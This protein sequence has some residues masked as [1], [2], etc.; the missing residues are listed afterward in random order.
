MGVTYGFACNCCGG[1]L[2]AAED[3]GFDPESHFAAYVDPPVKLACPRCQKTSHTHWPIDPATVRS[4]TFPTADGLRQ[5][6]EA[7][8]YVFARRD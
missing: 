5:T 6:G 3:P 8:D 1:A 4:S 7:H 2:A